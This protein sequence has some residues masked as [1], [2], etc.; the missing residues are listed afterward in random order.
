MARGELNAFPIVAEPPGWAAT[1]AFPVRKY[2]DF[3]VDASNSELVALILTIG[4][5]KTISPVT[6]ASS[7]GRCNTI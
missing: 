7:T 4:H 5:V 3:R 2:T 6:A 1:L